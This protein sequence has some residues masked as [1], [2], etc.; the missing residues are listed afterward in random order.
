MDVVRQDADGDRREWQSSFCAGVGGP[1]AF[2][3]AN[4]EIVA[5][6]GNCKRE[7]RDSA[8]DL[9]AT[10]TGHRSLPSR[11]WWARRFAPLPTLRI[12]SP[13]ALSPAACAPRA[14]RNRWRRPI[15][16]ARRR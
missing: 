3:M 8:F 4:Q 14:G 13:A 9:D 15:P 16:S 11:F 2:N 1:Q 10:I 12:I 7:K 5:A 6:V